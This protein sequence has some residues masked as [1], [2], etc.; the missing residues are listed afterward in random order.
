MLRNPDGLAVPLRDLASLRQVSSR[1]QISHDGGRRMQTVSVSVG[2]RAVCDFVREAQAR[3][4]RE[5]TMPKGTYAVFAGESEARSQ[6]LHDLLV[7]G[8]MAGVGIRSEEHTSELQS[9]MRLSYAVFCLN[10]KKKKQ[11]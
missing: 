7:Y 6:S 3:V 11:E 4:N 8:A 5:I 10:K 2:G 9:L 1:Y